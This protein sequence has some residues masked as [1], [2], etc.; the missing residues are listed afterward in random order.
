MQ[1]M[2]P[3]GLLDED[4]YAIMDDKAKKTK[5]QSD[6]DEDPAGGPKTKFK[7]LALK[8]VELVKSDPSALGAFKSAKDNRGRMSAV[9][10]AAEAVTAEELK[11]VFSRRLSRA[12]KNHAIVREEGNFYLKKDDFKHALNLFSTV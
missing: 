9:L 6:D 7:A 4:F 8:A 3:S 2:G 12:H 5:K 11:S 10:G 1:I